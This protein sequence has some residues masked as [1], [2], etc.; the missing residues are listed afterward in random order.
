MPDIIAHR[1]FQGIYPENTVAA[2]RNATSGEN[3]PV[4]DM[5]EIDVQPC[6]G[7]EVVVFHDEE[8][9]KHGDRGLT[10][11]EGETWRT[12]C[13]EVLSAEVLRSG[14]TVPRLEE[15]LEA[16]P[17]DVG[18]NIEFKDVDS[19]EVQ[20][21]WGDGTHPGLGRSL[22]AEERERRTEIWSDFV[23]GVLETA[24]GFENDLLVSSFFEGAI[25]ATRRISDVPTAFLFWESIEEGF[26]VVERHDC[27]AVHPPID[28]I[29]GVFFGGEIYTEGSFDDIDLVERA[30]A[31]GRRVN[32]WTV[33]TWFQAD[34]MLESGVDGLIA[35]YPLLTLFSSRE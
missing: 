4:P 33:D 18:V 28:M 6:E 16:V 11:K 29:K 30:H 7:G 35:D 31:E 27:E 12:G 3:H 17:D 5:V 14:E 9:M 13:D 22:N 2:V 1:G 19:E 26:E 25:A 8:L 32:V 10:D 24:S 21:T 15:V 20:F 34:R 23:K